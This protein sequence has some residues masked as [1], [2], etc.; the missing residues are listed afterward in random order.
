ML[1]PQCHEPL[2]I[3]EYHDIELDAC[4][5]CHGVWFDAQEL[6]Q[7]FELAGAGAAYH[8]LE[9][10]L[11]RLPHAEPRRRCPRCRKRL[12]PVRAPSAKDDLILDE[13]PY[14]HGIWFD[15][16]ELEALLRASLGS[17]RALEEVRGYLGEFMAPV[18]AGQAKR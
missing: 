3:V 18:K 14:E 11:D 13:C 8:K 15:A 2:V 12:E 6:R 7:M 5:D 9:A 4:P 10:Q 16:G 1:C 17:E